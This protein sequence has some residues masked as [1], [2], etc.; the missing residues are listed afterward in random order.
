MLIHADGIFWNAR[1]FLH[2]TR[3]GDLLKSRAHQ[4]V[5]VLSEW[6]RELRRSGGDGYG[7]SR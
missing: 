1:K 4:N 6:S 2:L 5:D 7:F 3:A